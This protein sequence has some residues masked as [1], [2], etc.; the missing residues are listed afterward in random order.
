[1]LVIQ[2]MG[3]L[4]SAFTI[5][6]VQWLSKEEAL[7]ANSLCDALRKVWHPS[8]PHLEKILNA[9]RFSLEGKSMFWRELTDLCSRFDTY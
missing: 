8:K 1:M 6:L 4:H 2:E 5:R 9:K 7:V 3:E